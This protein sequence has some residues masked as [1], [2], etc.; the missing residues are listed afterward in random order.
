MSNFNRKKNSRRHA[1][2][3]IFWL[4]VWPA[5]EKHVACMWNIKCGCFA[6]E[7]D[8]RMLRKK[9]GGNGKSFITGNLF[10]RLL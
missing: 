3:T 4:D 5:R 1:P 2:H 6:I 9:Y 7:E 8:L 10:S